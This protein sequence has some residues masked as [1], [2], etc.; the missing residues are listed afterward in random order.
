MVIVDLLCSTVL[1]GIGRR[2]CG[3]AFQQWTGLDIGD[4]PVRLFFGAT[5]AFSAWLAGVP[6]EF[7]IGV[8]LLTWAGAASGNFDALGMG[9]GKTSYVHDFLGMTAHGVISGGLLAIG[10]AL[11]DYHWLAPLV[12]GLLCGPCYEAGYRLSVTRV[13]AWLPSWAN[14]PIQIAELMWGAVMGIGAFISGVVL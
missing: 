8:V 10:A 7:G 13:N 3:G 9:R 1:G 14:G 2:V 4:L 5:L 11:L 12:A 6:W